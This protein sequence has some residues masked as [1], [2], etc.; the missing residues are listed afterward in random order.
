M[1]GKM[2]LAGTSEAYLAIVSRYYGQMGSE[3]ER[4]PQRWGIES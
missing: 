1:Y 4:K 3:F 2:E